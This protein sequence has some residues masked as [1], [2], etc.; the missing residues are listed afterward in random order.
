MN[1]K[2]S[3]KPTCGSQFEDGEKEKWERERKRNGICGKKRDK[4]N[5]QCINREENTVFSSI[6]SCL[7][8]ICLHIHNTYTQTHELIYKSL[9]T[10]HHIQ[11]AF[12][13]FIHRSVYW[14]IRG[15][16]YVSV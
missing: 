7:S 15:K 2:K 4:W 5:N 14:K 11:D 12:G 10:Y 3:R 1:W 8:F 16:S 13:Q 9:C 6:I